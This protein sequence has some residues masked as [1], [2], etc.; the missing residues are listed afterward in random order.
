MCTIHDFCVGKHAPFCT[1]Y[2]VYDKW[3]EL[4]IKSNLAQNKF[5][6]LVYT[7][8]QNIINHGG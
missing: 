2:M 1:K 5:E 8:N 6:S 7:L 3:V 4:I